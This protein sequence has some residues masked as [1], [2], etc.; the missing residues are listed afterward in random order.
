MLL[1]LQLVEGF[2][3]C[4]ER[5][6]T[7]DN[8]QIEAT[9]AELQFAKLLYLHD[10]QFRIM[11]PQGARASGDDFELCLPS[12]PVVCA[13]AKCKIEGR[14][15]NAHSVANTLNQARNQFPADKPSIIF[16]KVPQHWFVQVGMAAE[17]KR[18]ALQFLRGLGR[19][20]SVKSYIFHVSFLNQ[21]TLHRHAFDEITNP[22][23]RFP[24]KRNWDLFKGFVVPPEWN[25]N[26]P[27]WIQL[28]HFK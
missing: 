21:Q 15:I 10:I 17:L 20:V 7:G 25:G 13:D 6:R 9:Y 2:S 26:H 5:L 24:P 19:V 22:N 27:K 14:D 12:H 18:I 8:E 3:E 23:N 4:V 11:S 1:N 28:M 16:V